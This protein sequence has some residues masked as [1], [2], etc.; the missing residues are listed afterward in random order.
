M[1]R[2]LYIS[3]DGLMEP[4]GRSQVLQYVCGLAAGHSM[5]LVTYEKPS[6]LKDREGLAALQKTVRE[7]GIV[8]RPLRY[9][10]RPTLL[11]TSFDIAVGL[12][13]CALICARERVDIVHARSYVPGLIGLALKRVMGLRFLFDMRGFWPDQRIDDGFWVTTGFAYRLAKWFERHLL[14][15]AD[16]VVTLTHS[17]VRI[18]KS[19]PYLE[20]RGQKFEVIPTCTNLALFK[21]LSRNQQRKSFRLGFVGSVRLYMFDE[22]L[23]CFLALRSARADARLVVVSRD[24]PEA[25]RKRVETA[26]VPLS[27][28][29]VKSV[30][31]GLVPFEMNEMDAGIFFLA[32]SPARQGISPTKLGEFLA[33][34]VP[35]LTNAGVGDFEAIIGN[36]GSGVILRE[37]TPKARAEA[38][39]S[40]LQLVAHDDIRQRCAS[41]AKEYFNLDA[42]VAAYSRI[43]DSLQT[44]AP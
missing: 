14:V 33:C 23:A 3:Y 39:A 7:L 40:L 43:Y 25:L 36:S 5:V 13:V 26:G 11:A 4:L 19:F 31:F 20:G 29:E 30:P 41:A 42:G 8:W 10:K 35:C 28:L 34:G 27:A 44:S 1:A 2:V 21:P 16:V 37:F 32:P 18:I 38:V 24:E 15:Q 12:L 9:H 22:V 17:A 6:D